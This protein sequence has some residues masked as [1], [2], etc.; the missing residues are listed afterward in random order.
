MTAARRTPTPVRSARPSRGLRR[1]TPP[2]ANAAAPVPRRVRRSEVRRA[3]I[4]HAAARAFREHGYHETSLDQ[5]AEELLLSKGSVYYYF[6]SKEEI[7]FALHDHSLDHA[8]KLLDE[9]R[10]AESSPVRQLSRVIEGHLE[11]IFDELQASGIVLDFSALGDER[12]RQVVAKRDRFE[13][14]LR[15]IVADGVRAGEFVTCDPTVVAFAILGSINW[16]ARWFSP[17]GRLTPKAV[18]AQFSDYLVRGLVCERRGAF[19][20]LGYKGNKQC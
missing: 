19:C 6:P 18:A 13:R 8:Q 16:V 11:I 5:I 20:P 12:R 17:G 14:G 1:V 10:R 4:L 7:L 3:D 9:I 15:Q 2:A